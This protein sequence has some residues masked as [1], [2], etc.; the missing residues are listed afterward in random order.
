VSEFAVPLTRQLPYV[1]RERL[2]AGGAT[3]LIGKVVSVPDSRHV[4]IEIGGAQVTIPKL[5]SYA[6]PAA[7]EP[8]YVLSDRAMTLAL[9]TIK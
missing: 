1:L 2:Q 6:A 4:R 5:A 9:G 8:C 7:G 3:L